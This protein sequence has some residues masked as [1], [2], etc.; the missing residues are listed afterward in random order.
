MVMSNFRKFNIYIAHFS[1]K[2]C[3]L[4]GWMLHWFFPAIKTIKFNVVKLKVEQCGNIHTFVLHSVTH[5]HT[6][7]F[8]RYDRHK[9]CRG[10]RCNLFYIFPFTISTFY[11]F[12]AIGKHNTHAHDM[13][14]VLLHCT[15]TLDTTGKKTPPEPR[16]SK[17]ITNN[18]RKCVR[19]SLSAISMATHNI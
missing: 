4:S 16:L 7:T 15:K 10:C 12:S 11:A 5:T 8:I 3:E 1:Q 9:D 14:L 18:K 6:H 17:Q 2:C 19:L 13:I